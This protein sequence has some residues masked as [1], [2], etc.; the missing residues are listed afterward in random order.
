MRLCRRNRKPFTRRSGTDRLSG[1]SGERGGLRQP[2]RDACGGSGA[3]APDERGGTS[4]QPRIQLG[5]CYGANLGPLRGHRLRAGRRGGPFAVKIADVSE[6]Y[7]P[8]G[9]GVR[10]YVHHKLEFAARLGHDLTI[11][12]P[13]SETRIENL[14]GGRIS[15]V[16]APLLP[17][18]HNY[19]MFWNASDV[20]HALDNAAPDIVEGSSPWRGGWL[21]AQWPG[22]AAKILFMHSDPIASY[23]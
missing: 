4:A 22:A 15:W 12:A 17:F 20:W 11:I 2:H 23:P 7:S 3:S 5:R 8:T 10:S 1:L 14:R 6:F 19:R 18:D 21:A 13:G 9:G 16:K